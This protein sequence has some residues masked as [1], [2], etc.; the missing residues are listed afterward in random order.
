M[1]YRT[2]RPSYRIFR[3]AWFSTRAVTPSTVQG[4]LTVSWTLL[5]IIPGT[6][7]GGLYMDRAG[8]GMVLLYRSRMLL[9]VLILLSIML[10]A[11]AGI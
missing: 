7:R 6:L 11:G 8:T 1:D 4:V 9:D 2:P 5:S 10:L 3:A